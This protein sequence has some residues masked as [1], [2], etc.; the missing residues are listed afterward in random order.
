MA[1]NLHPIPKCGSVFL[2]CQFVTFTPKSEIQVSSRTSKTHFSIT[3]H[4]NWI[5]SYVPSPRPSVQFPNEPRPHAGHQSQLNSD[6]SKSPM[7][8]IGIWRYDPTAREYERL[9]LIFFCSVKD[10]GAR[11]TTVAR[12]TKL[13]CVRMWLY[14]SGRVASQTRRACANVCATAE[15]ELHT[16]FFL[17]IHFNEKFCIPT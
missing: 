17:L 2:T 11:W 3:P 16:Q 5:R 9:L 14:T 10:T 15:T 13:G 7:A 6:G 4:C 12:R 8:W 1:S